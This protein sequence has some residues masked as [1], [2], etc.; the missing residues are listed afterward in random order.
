MMNFQHILMDGPKEQIPAM[1][2]VS[3]FDQLG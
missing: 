1:N 3:L 2:R